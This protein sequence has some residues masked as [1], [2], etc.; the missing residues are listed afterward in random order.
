MVSGP[1]GGREVVGAQARGA[2]RLPADDQALFH[3]GARECRGEALEEGLRPPV[4]GPGHGLEETG[5]SPPAGP[6][7]SSRAFRWAMRG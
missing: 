5:H 1:I 2:P 6:S 4:D 3:A 7:G